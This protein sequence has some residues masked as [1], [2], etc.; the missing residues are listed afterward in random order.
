MPFRPDPVLQRFEHLQRLR[1]RPVIG[2]VVSVAAVAAAGAL[3]IPLSEL[4]SG[5]PFITFYPAVAIAAVVGGT[6]AGILAIVLAA[7]VADYVALPPAFAFTFTTQALIQTALFVLVLALIVGLIGLL[8]HM[9]DLTARQAENG[10]LIL[11]SQPAGVVAVDDEGRITLV[12]STVE[13]QLGYS[14]EELL[15]RSVDQLVPIDM[16]AEHV[17]HRKRFMHKPD[18]RRMGAG[19]DLNALAKDGS[20]VPVE[21]GLSPVYQNGRF[22]ALATIVDISERKQLEWRAQMLSD[23]VWHRAHNLLTIVQA[24]ALRMLPARTSRD[25][26]QSLAALARTQEVVRSG[27]PTLLA[28]LVARELAGFPR[29]YTIAGCDIALSERAAVDFTLIVHELATNALKYGALSCGKGSVRVSC[30]RTDEHF[31][32]LWQETG[33]PAPAAPAR[34]GYGRTILE[35]LVR[36]F[37]TGV[38]QEYRPEGLHYELVMPIAAISAAGANA[39]YAA[40]GAA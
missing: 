6:R 8:N 23:E 34:R 22:G 28:D 26:I 40:R 2:Y 36:S 20:L 12:N 37:C 21:V 1:Q 16:R 31:T 15:D 7:I 35:T 4:L 10:R 39:D 27:A 14:R 30:A 11:E 9:I 19:R 5:V 25:F 33:G 3:R 18:V 38:T 29:K 32:F 17:E 24:M 13:R